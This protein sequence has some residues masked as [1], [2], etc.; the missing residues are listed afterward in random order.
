MILLIRHA[1]VDAHC[2]FLPG[3]MPGVHLNEV[4]RR[5]AAALGTALRQI[6]LT[7]VYSSP[8]E[9]ARETADALT[10]RPGHVTIVDELNEIDFGEW[11]GLPYNQLERQYE[12][13][14]F[15]RHRARSP[16]PGGEWML[17]VQMRAW[18]AIGRLQRAHHGV[19]IAVVSHHDVL[20]SVVAKVMDVPLDRLDSFRIDPASVSSL[21]WSS[22]G[23]EITQMNNRSYS[24]RPVPHAIELAQAQ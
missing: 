13:I 15:M 11:T 1:M 3:R 4:G 22:T 16:I 24:E 8:L 14:A 18:R 23:F 10:D 17:N 20:R 5:Q 7:A 6:P 12:W 21:E 9:R 19:A 2:R